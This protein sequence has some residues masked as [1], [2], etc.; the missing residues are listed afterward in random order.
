MLACANNHIF[1]LIQLHYLFWLY[2][3]PIKANIILGFMALFALRYQYVEIIVCWEIKLHYCV[4]FS[5]LINNDGWLLF[6][7]P[8]ATVLSPPHPT[9]LHPPCKLKNERINKEI[10]G[11]RAKNLERYEPGGAPRWSFGVWCSRCVCVWR[12]GLQSISYGH[13]KCQHAPVYSL[14]HLVTGAHLKMMNKWLM[15]KMALC[16]WSMFQNKLKP[17]QL[18]ILTLYYLHAECLSPSLAPQ[19]WS[20]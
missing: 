2:H 9:P 19:L 10:K 6:S 5:C 3:T 15:R 16:V 1:W 4:S 8:P 11:E 20:S 7:S 18:Y 13:S 14:I 12:G 17:A